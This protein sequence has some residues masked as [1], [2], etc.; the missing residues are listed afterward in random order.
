[1]SRAGKILQQVQRGVRSV[2]YGNP[3]YHRI[4]SA[5]VGA[6]ELRFTPPDIWPGDAQAGMA[7]IADQRRLFADHRRFN[8]SGW[9]TEVIR[10]LRAVGSEVARRT[11]VSLIENWLQQYDSWNEAEW[12]ADILGERIASWIGFYEFYAPAGDLEFTEQLTSSLAR[13]WQHLMRTVPTMLTGIGGLQ[14]VKGLVYGGLNFAE[15]EK[16]LGLGCDLLRRQ[17][18]AEILPDGGHRTR[19]PSVQLHM[20][21]SLIDLRAVLRTARLEVPNEIKAAIE[22]MIPALRFFRHG[23]GGLALFHGGQA[24]SSLLIEAVLTQS[25][26]RS[27]AL[28]RLPETGYE[29][30]TSGRSLLLAD[31][32]R[33]PAHGYDDEA[34]AGLLSVEFG[35]G[36]ERLIVNCGS[37]PQADTTW[38]MAC[39]ATAAHTTLTVEDKNACEILPSGGVGQRPRQTSIQRYEQDGSQFIEMMHDGYRQRFSV[40]HHRILSLS[41]D[42]DELHGSDSLSGP[43]GRNFT[44]RWHL[45]PD[46]QASLLHSGQAALLRTASGNGWRLRVDGGDLGLE[47]SIYCG[48]GT[49]RRTLQ[50]KVSGRT[51][52]DPTT[53][54]WNLVREK[55]S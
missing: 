14:A 30:L 32:G 48:D 20:L 2:T 43:M 51:H 52:G 22:A 7:I 38:R 13:Q 1:M 4:L 37:L 47:P 29:R 12:A 5:N 8:K 53:V 23:D 55:R 26:V 40:M 3:L 24:E 35:N 44:L 33:P 21:R 15:G 41:A 17:L 18:A 31:V 46:V 11:V 36:R 19:S 28:R 25:E 27:R 34:H 16:A 50:L 10:D 9:Q 49:P 54:A 39:A 45:H 6:E 42:G